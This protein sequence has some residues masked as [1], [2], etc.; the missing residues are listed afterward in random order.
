MTDHLTVLGKN[1]SAGNKR[2]LSFAM[3]LLVTPAVE[4]MDN[5]LTG[6]DPCARRGMIKVI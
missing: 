5:P 6:V 1:L 2:K 4:L 3:S